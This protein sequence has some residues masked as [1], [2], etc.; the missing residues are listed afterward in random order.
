M[1]K[2]MSLIFKANSK[3]LFIGANGTG[4]QSFCD[5]DAIWASTINEINIFGLGVENNNYD[6]S[7]KVQVSIDLC[8]LESN[9]EIAYSFV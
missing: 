8:Q 7:R 9:I 1:T 6:S 5:K 3:K 4:F 2:D